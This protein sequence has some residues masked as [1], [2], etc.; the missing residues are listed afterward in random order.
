MLE[1][2]QK[3]DT[4]GVVFFTT[5]AGIQQQK[6]WQGADRVPV[7]ILQVLYSLYLKGVGANPYAGRIRRTRARYTCS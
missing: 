5:G 1:S 7:V 6:G 4:D 2:L 3:R